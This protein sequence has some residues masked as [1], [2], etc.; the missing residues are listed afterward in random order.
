LRRAAAGAVGVAEVD[1]VSRVL[2]RGF[3]NPLG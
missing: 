3:R 2:W 1:T